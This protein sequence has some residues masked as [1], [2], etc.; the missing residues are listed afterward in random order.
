MRLDE[1]LREN[2]TGARKA[3]AYAHSESVEDVLGSMVR[4]MKAALRR[5]EYSMRLDY[6][7]WE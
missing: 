6:A 2:L 4:Q 5:Q 7:S 1:K 3:Q